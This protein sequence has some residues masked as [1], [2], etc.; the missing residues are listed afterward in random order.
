MSTNTGI[1]AG[2]V[3]LRGIFCVGFLFLGFL[4]LLFLCLYGLRMLLTR[5]CGV[6]GGDSDIGGAYCVF[7]AGFEANL[8]LRRLCRGSVGSNSVGFELAVSMGDR[9]GRDVIIGF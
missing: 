9:T 2:A 5:F 7:L 8:A 4:F 3:G 6:S 1:R